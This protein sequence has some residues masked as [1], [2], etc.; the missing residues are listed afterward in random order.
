MPDSFIR[1]IAPVKLTGSHQKHNPI[2]SGGRFTRTTAGIRNQMPNVLIRKLADTEYVRSAVA[3]RA[4]LSAFKEKP[5]PRILF[6]LSVIAFSYLIGWPVI[7]ALG[8]LSVYLHQPMIVAAGGPIMYLVS[9]LTFIVGAYFAG[10]KYTRVL[11]RWLTRIAMERLTGGA[12]YRA[13]P[14]AAC[15]CPRKLTDRRSR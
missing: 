15:T 1:K 8:V 4:D 5:T 13:D 6:G 14:S 12:V 9:H 11:M 7:T 3:D 10:A 2:S